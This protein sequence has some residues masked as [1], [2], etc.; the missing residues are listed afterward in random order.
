MVLNEAKTRGSVLGWLF[1]MLPP[2]GIGIVIEVD[3]QHYYSTY[4]GRDSPRRYSG[5]GLRTDCSDCLAMKYIFL[6]HGFGQS[7]TEKI[8]I[9]FCRTLFDRYALL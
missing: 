6:G 7:D 2:A 4:D 3:G 9:K 1:L 8:Q 5:N